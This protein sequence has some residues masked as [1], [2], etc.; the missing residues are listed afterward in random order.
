MSRIDIQEITQFLHS[1]KKSNDEAREMI[2]GIQNQVE[3]YSSDTTI[4]GK[5]VEASQ[6]YYNKTYSVIC[7][8]IIEALNESE[9]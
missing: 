4:K 2:Q 7:K 6:Q 1:L 9:N 3:E 5:A 8:T